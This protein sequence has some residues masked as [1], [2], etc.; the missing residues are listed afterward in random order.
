MVIPSDP[1]WQSKFGS[2]TP[3][4]SIFPMPYCGFLEAISEN[5]S[6]PRIDKKKPLSGASRSLAALPARTARKASVLGIADHGCL[7]PRNGDRE[8]LT[9]R[10]PKLHHVGAVVLGAEDHDAVL[11]GY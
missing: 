7:V 1:A 6:R 3:I 11:A 9:R 10:G 5:T 2:F 8:R 4:L